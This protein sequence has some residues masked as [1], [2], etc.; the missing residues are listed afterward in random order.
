MRAASLHTI[1]TVEA[2]EAEGKRVEA[3]EVLAAQLEHLKAI[4]DG[5]PAQ[6]CTRLLLTGTPLQNDPIEL[7]SLLNHFNPSFFDKDHF[8]VLR[9]IKGET[10]QGVV[11]KLHQ[12]C[13]RAASCHPV[14]PR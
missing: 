10:E 7:W 6:P 3:A 12:V 5:K 13:A 14:P 11:S 2:L 1:A 4:C 9:A 8:R